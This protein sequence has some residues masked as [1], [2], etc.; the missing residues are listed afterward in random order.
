MRDPVLDPITL[1]ILWSK[2]VSVVDEAAVAL[3]RS[4]YSAII[5]IA[6]DFG[7]VLCDAHGRLLVSTTRGLSFFATM[8]PRTVR[9][10]IE[11][12]GGDFA[13]GDVAITNDP[14]I[15]AG[16]LSDIAV[17]SPIWSADSLVAYVASIAHTSDIGG[18][19]HWQG[20]S[21]LFEEGLHIPVLRIR[22]RGDLN[23]TLVDMIRANVRA[24]K[25]VIGDINAMTAANRIAEIRLQTFLRE[26]DLPSLERLADAIEDLCEK[27]MRESIRDLPDG[28]Y[29]C[30]LPVDGLGEPLSLPVQVRVIGDEMEVDYSFSP[31]HVEVGG[32]NCVYNYTYGA[33]THALQS[34][35]LPSVP[36]SEGCFRPV[37]VLAPAGS[38]LNAQYPAP[39]ISR[40]NIGF[41]LDALISGALQGVLPDRVMAG[42]G[43]LFHVRP[44]G[45]YLNG[46]D[47]AVST[48]FG[49]G[50][51]ALN[52]LDGN[53]TCIF[54]S[55]AGNVSVEVFEN[56][57]PVVVTR[58]EYVPGSGGIGQWRGGLGQRMTFEVDPRFTNT[59]KVSFFSRNII[60]PPNGLRGGQDGAVASVR[61]NDRVVHPD[62]KEI[63]QG[64][65]LLRTVD[66]LTFETAGGGGYGPPEERILEAITDDIEQGLLGAQ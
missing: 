2:L 3:T 4:A 24:P 13:E 20:T 15:S 9:A 26:Y 55:D 8:L 47:F 6:L 65:I 51:G 59:V 5:S 48:I 39:T 62:S 58:K 31:T 53:N 34:L 14:W 10:V 16:H 23:Q 66:A 27:A 43:F 46:G 11:Q 52:G 32:I 54:P 28:A 21:D 17:V 18:S 33:T 35:L 64:L 50:M 29:E 49:G 7:V 1:E 36:M 42:S 61:L 44:H 41:Y 22:N 57:S 37:R 30:M 63:M 12:F 40:T 60:S 45:R 19:V 56:R 38:I 25:S